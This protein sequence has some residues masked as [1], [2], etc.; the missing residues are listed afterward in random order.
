MEE[1]ETVAEHCKHPDCSY[2]RQ[3]EAGYTPYCDYIGATGQARRC[4]I[5]ECDKYT[6][7]KV[8]FPQDMFRF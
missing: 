6:T 5:S 4:K 2:R 1:H 8:V 7:E 3:I